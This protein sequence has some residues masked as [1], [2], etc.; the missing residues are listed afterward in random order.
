MKL[1]RKVILFGML[2]LIGSIFIATPVQAKK[3]RT[4]INFTYEMHG[5]V[6]ERQWITDSGILQARR[7][8]HYGFILTSDC[9]LSG[10]LFYLG[11]LTLFSL[12]TYEGRGGG[13]FEFTGI[14]D[15]EAASFTG[16]SHLTIESFIISGTFNVHGTGSL[17]G[18][19]KGTILG[20]LG[21]TTYTATLTFWN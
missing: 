5:T 2:I 17:L 9:D 11:D 3:T 18:H 10:D 4:T 7:N 8:P 16:K 20:V 21:G 19:L 1:G 14:Y 15:G 6:A 12:I 13:P